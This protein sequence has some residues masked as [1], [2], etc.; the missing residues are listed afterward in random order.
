MK[1]I[2][3]PVDFS[4]T[5]KNALKYAMALNEKTGA[6]IVLFHSYNIPLYITDVPVVIPDPE[7]PV[8]IQKELNRL[9]S[10]CKRKHPDMTFR[11]HTSEGLSWNEII[12]EEKNSKADL[13][14]MGVNDTSALQRMVFGS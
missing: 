11:T 7:M 3:V 8:E 5:S 13:V 14:I 1:T 2:L 9:K 12:S 6:A 10:D 4:E